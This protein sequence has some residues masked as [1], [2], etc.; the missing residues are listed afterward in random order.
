MDKLQKARLEINEIDKEMAELF[1][2]RM[3]AVRDVA[4]YKKEHGLKIFDPVREEDVI[5]RNSALIDDE[6]IREYYVNYLR[7]SMSVSKL[8]QDRICRE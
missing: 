3:D 4:E 8:Y 6:E 2:K 7:A 5:R 1:K